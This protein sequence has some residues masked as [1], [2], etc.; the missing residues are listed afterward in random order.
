M[1]DK[2]VDDFLPALK[3]VPDSFV[4]SKMIKKLFSALYADDNILYFIENSGNAV[5]PCNEMGI[6]NKDVNNINLDDTN[7]AKNDPDTIIHIR[8]SAWRIKLE[9]CKALRKELNEELMHIASHN[10]RWQ[11]FLRQEKK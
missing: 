2:A 8:L 1:C 3:F 5:F 6:V 10:R 9:K 11:N 7:Y 4:T